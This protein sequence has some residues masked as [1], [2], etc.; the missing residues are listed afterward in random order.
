MHFSAMYRLRWYRRAFTAM[1]R[2]TSAGWENK[3]FSI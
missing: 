1:S 3:L 2:Q